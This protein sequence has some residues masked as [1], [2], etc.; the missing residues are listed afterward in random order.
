MFRHRHS[1]ETPS[2]N[3]ASTADISF[4]LLIFFLVVSSMDTDKG[5]RRQLPPPPQQ[6]EQT[7]DI[8]RSHVLQVTLDANDQVTCN[9]DTVTLTTLAAKVGQ[10][11]AVDPEQN[12]VAVE[13]DRHA[14]YDAYFHMQQTIIGAY[15][16]AGL[17]PRISEVPRNEAQEGGGRP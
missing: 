10:F 8:A 4:M 9:G 1:S 7:L 11:A 5:M 15:R 17:P 16:Q 12:V 2:L 6:E 3:T 14:H 13:T